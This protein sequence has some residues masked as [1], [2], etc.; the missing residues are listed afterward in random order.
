MPTPQQLEN[1]RNNALHIT[2]FI[3]HLHDYFQDVVSDVFLRINQES[4]YDAGQKWVSFVYSL[5][6]S[7]FADVELKGSD[8]FSSFMSTI[9]SSYD[10][11]TPSQEG[12]NGVI[13]DVWTRLS[14]TFLQANDD[15]ALIATYPE[16]Y[17]DSSYF[18]ETLNH[19]FYIKDL[20]NVF[21]PSQDDV[22]N[23]GPIVFASG[24]DILI[25]K[26]RYALTRYALG[27]KWSILHDPSKLFWPNASEDDVK[28]FAKNMIKNNQ[29]ILVIWKPDESGTCGSCP[30][31][32]LSSTEPRIG[33][34]DWYSNWDYFHGASPTK[35]MMSWLIKDDGYGTILNPDAIATRH[36]VFYEWGL[37]GDL[38]Q[39][40]NTQLDE[41]IKVIP[42]KKDGESAL[43]WFNLFKRFG[44]RNLEEKVIEKAYSDP[45]FYHDLVKNPKSTLEKE[46]GLILPEH[47]TI[48]IIQEDIGNYTLVLPAIGGPK[49]TY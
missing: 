48:T 40:S 5:T 2:S 25:A 41:K 49:R 39:H 4:N 13:A 36:E 17:W 3:N 28:N 10:N 9:L 29:D 14:K 31:H 11:N 23:N 8:T 16:N 45:Q 34:G 7:A 42:S 15:L 32:G 18:S 22:A 37:E 21:F 44:R 20:G 35:D 33:V 43:Q 47:I 38:S 1:V 19:T 24:T 30:T 26:F 6:M 12:L 46:F 27:K